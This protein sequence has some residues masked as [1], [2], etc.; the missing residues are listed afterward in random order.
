M[1]ALERVH[2]QA[3]FAEQRRQRARGGGN[4]RAAAGGGLDRGKTEAFQEGGQHQ[5]RGQVQQ[6]DQ[7]LIRQVSREDDP[8]GQP[9]GLDLPPQLFERA[10][11]HL[12]P[13]LPHHDELHILE[14]RDPS[15]PCEHL[16]QRAE[17]LVRSKSSDV[18]DRAA[19]SHAERG[20]ARPG[21]R[22]V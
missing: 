12:L 11:E 16:D 18:D 20:Q 4:D 1:L 5:N 3:T 6:H 22:A 19:R 2:V 14:L 21:T 7:L 9:K 13:E 17:I 10:V 8:L 15:H